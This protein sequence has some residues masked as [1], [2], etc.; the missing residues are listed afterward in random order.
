MQVYWGKSEEKNTS[1]THLI[2]EL[3]QLLRKH[4]NIFAKTGSHWKSSKHPVESSKSEMNY[5]QDFLFNQRLRRNNIKME[6]VYNS[7]TTTPD[8]TEKYIYFAPNYQPEANVTPPAGVYS[9]FTLIVDI[10]AASIPDDWIIY[11]K[12]HPS[13]FMPEIQGSLARD[14]NYYDRLNSYK[15]VR[16]IPYDF[17]TF[18]LIDNSQAV[19]TP[20]GTVGW[21]AAVRGKPVLVFGQVWYVGC[22]SIFLIE[23]FEDCRDAIK[24]IIAGYIPDPKD[25]ELYASAVEAVAEKDLLIRDFPQ[26]L[27]NCSNPDYELQRVAK[28]LYKAYHRQCVGKTSK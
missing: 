18:K 14:R 6:S 26:R 13:T 15:N 10:L 23:T 12:E 22:D 19:A 25:I 2:R 8:L 4:P 28:E 3:L 11:Y 7:F 9:S 27:K 16:I 24:K 20:T 17:N 5:L 21:E 1:P